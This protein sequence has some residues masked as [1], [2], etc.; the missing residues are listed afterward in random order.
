LLP[1]LGTSTG[2]ILAAYIATKGGTAYDN[3][4]GDNK[5]YGGG[6]KTAKTFISNLEAGQW[7]PRNKG[8]EGYNPLLT[9]ELHKGVYGRRTGQWEI[10]RLFAGT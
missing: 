1:A 8:K 4:I 9:T 2:S 5:Q 3:I 6:V 7:D 10:E